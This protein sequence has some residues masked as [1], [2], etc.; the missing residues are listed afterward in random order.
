VSLPLERW[1]ISLDPEGRTKQIDAELKQ[2]LAPFGA[3]RSARFRFAYELAFAV[4]CGTPAT[5][6]AVL[7]ALQQASG[8]NCS[9]KFPAVP[10]KAGEEGLVTLGD[11][12]SPFHKFRASRPFRAA[13]VQE[14]VV[15]AYQHSTFLHRTHAS[16]RVA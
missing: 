9:Y 3:S 5:V 12:L 14:A 11:V 10:T 2:K 4:V 15:E 6:Q 16:G 7:G 13:L 8:V 1:T